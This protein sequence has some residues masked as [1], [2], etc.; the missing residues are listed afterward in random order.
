MKA[1]DRKG[2]AYGVGVGPGDPVVLV[3]GVTSFCAAAARLGMALTEWDEPLH[4]LPA[5]HITDEKI[6]RSG[7]YVLMKAASRMKETKQLLMKNGREAAAVLNCGM[8]NELVCRSIEE[9]PDDAGYF[10][11]LVSKEP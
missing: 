9:I 8:E 2:T 7:A 1:S 3:S 10:T 4:V 6:E 11:L 5:A